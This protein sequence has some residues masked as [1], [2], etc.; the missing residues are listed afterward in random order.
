MTDEKYPDQ[1][2]DI[3]IQGYLQKESLHFRNLRKR[4]MVLRIFSD[5]IYI[6]H[7]H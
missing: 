4:W 1:H 5:Q 7:I 2:D 3:I 6:L